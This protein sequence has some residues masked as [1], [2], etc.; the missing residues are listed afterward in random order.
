M[1]IRVYRPANSA[2]LDFLDEFTEQIAETLVNNTNLIIMGDFNFH[3]NNSND[4]DVANFTD[5][6]T[7]FGL[8]QNVSHPTHC[9]NYHRIR[10]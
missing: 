6:M 7:A 1:V 10:Y 2:G 3:V 4:D 5:T 8:V 9:G